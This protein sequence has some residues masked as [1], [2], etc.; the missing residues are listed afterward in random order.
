MIIGQSFHP[1]HHA[2]FVEGHFLWDLAGAGLWLLLLMTGFLALVI[3]GR[4][5]T[6]EA[7]RV[8]LGRHVEAVLLVSLVITLAIGTSAHVPVF[9]G[10]G[11]VVAVSL[12]GA[13]VPTILALYFLLAAGFKRMVLSL[14]PL[15]LVSLATFFTSETVPE[16]GIIARPPFYFL[17]ALIAAAGAWAV[18]WRSLHAIPLAYAYGS[19]GALIGA[20]LLRIQWI[21]ETPLTAASIGGAD[22]MDLVFLMGMWSAALAMLPFAPRFLRLHRTDPDWSQVARLAH[23]RR[24]EKSLDLAERIV[25]GRLTEWRRAHGLEQADELRVLHE[26]T[27]GPVLQEVEDLRARPRPW[28]AD[29]LRQVLEDL[30][31]VDRRLQEPA[32]ADVASR[33]DRF[34]AGLIDLGPVLLV[35]VLATVGAFFMPLEQ[36]PDESAEAF[37]ARYFT[38][39]LILVVWSTVAAHVLYPFFAEWFSGGRT[40]GKAAMGLQVKTHHGSRPTGWAFF[41]RNL[42][43]LL[44]ILLVY[45]VP[46]VAPQDKGRQRLGDYFA[47]TYVAKKIVASIQDETT[48]EAPSPASADQWSHFVARPP[49]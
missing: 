10:P 19:L 24:G 17:P 30:A 37:A 9:V 38:A 13:V 18:A 21:I 33:Q 4:F 25:R 8:G 32:L 48:N 41:V 47:Q 49:R 36:G 45:L 35:A 29:A 12:L 16:M 7:E 34:L 11:G 22:A 42:T 39:G 6:L 20:D 15:A 5:M 14:V 23:G 2:R 1:V 3:P 31:G 46:F 27:A 26:S 40:L 28:D 43:R 44:D